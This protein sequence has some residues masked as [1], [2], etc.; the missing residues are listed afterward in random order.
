MR[1]YDACEFLYLATYSV[2]H[3]ISSFFSFSRKVLIEMA[4]FAVY[5]GKSFKQL[6]FE[7]L[8]IIVWCF[9]LTFFVKPPHYLDTKIGWKTS[10]KPRGNFCFAFI[11]G[12]LV[13][14]L[15]EHCCRL[16]W[17]STWVFETILDI[18][19]L[20]P[21]LHR[22][23][24]RLFKTKVRNALTDIAYIYT[25]QLANSKQVVL[26]KTLNSKPTL[27]SKRAKHNGSIM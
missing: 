12:F 1:I 6:H 16:N 4:H 8:K 2:V 5:P 3:A 25:V 14:V 7:L 18:G 26:W 21:V 23:Y 15:E 10:H 24:D 27:D 20:L 22:I 9:Y 17:E 13:R 11:L 19:I